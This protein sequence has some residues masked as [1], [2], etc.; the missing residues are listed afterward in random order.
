MLDRGPFDYYAWVRTLRDQRKM[1]WCDGQHV[2][3]GLYEY[4]GKT[5]CPE[6]RPADHLPPRDSP[7]YAPCEWQKGHDGVATWLL[8]RDGRHY[9]ALH[10]Q[11]II[12]IAW[13]RP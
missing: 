9:C 11:R 5:Y 4:D 1:K 8:P 12:S 10:L 3:M 13:W 6:H 2:T 7:S